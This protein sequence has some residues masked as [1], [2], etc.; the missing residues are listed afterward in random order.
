MDVLLP[1]WPA[2]GHGQAILTT[3]DHRFAFDIAQKGLEIESWD[4]KT[5]SQFLLHLLATNIGD[6]LSAD[7]INSA[8]QLS[9]KLS[10][11]ALAIS[12]M[13]GLIHGRG[14][15]IA[16]FIEEYDQQP[17]MIHGISDNKSINALWNISFKTLD[18]QSRAILG[19]LSFVSPDSV[20]QSL[21]QPNSGADCLP[22]AL[23][24][25]ANRFL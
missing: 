8:N 14:W 11:H 16:E 5:G 20:P 18:L 15:S 22:E 10:G 6:Q 17:Q 21:F 7:D 24:F 23:K 19:V 13:A 12:H 2:A 9:D 3:R 25:S 1:Y 4:A